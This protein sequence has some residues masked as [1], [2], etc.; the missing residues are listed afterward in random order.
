[1][2]ESQLLEQLT[3]E[4]EARRQR[5][6]TPTPEEYLQRFP[7]QADLVRRLFPAETTSAPPLPCPTVIDGGL[8]LLIGRYRVVEGLGRG[9]QGDV[10]RAVHPGLHQ[11]V[12]I[13]VARPGLSEE[14]RRRLLDEGR[15]LAKLTDPGLVRVF[16]ADEHQGRPFIVFEYVR[17]RSLADVI[18]RER[19]PPRRAAALVAQL[20]ETL[21]RV[22]QQGV[23]HHDLKP[24]N[25]LIDDSGK[26]RLLD[27]GV[28][29]LQ[30]PLLSIAAPEGPAGTPA[31]MAPEQARGQGEP[32][33]PST[34]VFGLGAVLYHLLT[35]QPPYQG[36]SLTALLEQARECRVKP[37]RDINRRI[38]AALDRICCKS[39]AA[40][41]AHRYAGAGA[42]ARAL[43]AWLR[44]GRLLG[45][46]AALA[47]LAALAVAV[48]LSSGRADRSAEMPEPRS[49]SGESAA[50]KDLFGPNSV[51]EGEFHFGGRPGINDGTMRVTV[52]ERSGER[53]RG[54]YL[55]N[56]G[57]YGW[58]IAGTISQG[59][60][61]WGFT[62]P[63]AGTKGFQTLV[64]NGSVE[65][66][67]SGD[68]LAG[69]FD[70]RSDRSMATFSLRRKK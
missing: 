34:D 37:P 35:G 29:A 1:M 53:F 2:K 19:L 31:Y 18:R 16:D 21:E 67:L 11:D 46:G 58:H 6:E 50:G 10:Y 15:I 12:V 27:F 52:T 63:M 43:R 42:M 38:P 23:S 32:L 28:A 40:D 69:R 51:W 33:G 4:L 22:H 47:I 56:P 13:K 55:T 61:R 64:G 48:W 24:A 66:T 39:M 70:D 45:L 44:R 20:A 3:E 7:D 17:G 41:P 68:V 25:V 57:N 62:E 36:T 8:P 9:G 59:Q 60:V 65:A 49:S 54:R 26:P 14:A 5:G 30:Q